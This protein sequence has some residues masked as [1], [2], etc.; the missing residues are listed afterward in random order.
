MYLDEAYR[1]L[2]LSPAATEEEVRAAHRDLTKVWHPDRF[3]HDPAMQWKAEEKLKLINEAFETIRAGGGHREPH[4]PPE[5]SPEAVPRNRMP[6]RLVW[7]FTFVFLA[8]FILVR[9]P[10]FGGLLLAGVLLVL[11]F[12]LTLRKW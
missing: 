5:W 2:D 9:R 3:A 10:T 4:P 8:L 12:L 11:A 6:G 1:V 7:V